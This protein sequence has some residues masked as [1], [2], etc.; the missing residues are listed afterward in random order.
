MTEVN[1]LSTMIPLDNVQNVQ[2][3]LLKLHYPTP[4]KRTK[5]KKRDVRLF[6]GKTQVVVGS[7]GKRQH[8]WY[9]KE[10]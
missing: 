9:N 5:E 4:V 1:C 2:Q 6:S 10:N 7:I 8:D 3:R